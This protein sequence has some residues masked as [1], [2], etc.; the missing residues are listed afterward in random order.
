[1]R[2]APRCLAKTRRGTECQCPAMRGKRRCRIHGGANPGAPKRNRNA[3]KHGL[4][5]GEHQALRRLVRL[6]A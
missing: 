4:R 3:W 5:S 6:L 1:M 2:S